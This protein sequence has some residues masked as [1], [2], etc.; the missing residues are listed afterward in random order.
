M[1]LSQ[2]NH[3]SIRDVVDSGVVPRFI[4]F[5]RDHSHPELQYESLWTLLNIASGPMEFT[6]N[7]IKNNAHIVFI[8]LLTTSRYYEIKEQ[9]MYVH[10]LLSSQ[11]LFHIVL[12]MIILNTFKT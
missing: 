6:G 10:F 1:V 8:D 12:L 2:P 3:P 11:F 9:A 7:V 5:C 4:Q